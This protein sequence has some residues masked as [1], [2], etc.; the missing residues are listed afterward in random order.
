MVMSDMRVQGRI[1]TDEG[2]KASEDGNGGNGC[3]D[4]R[5]GWSVWIGGSGRTRRDE[6]AAVACS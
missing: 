1:M 4:L 6:F 3:H 2:A 5:F